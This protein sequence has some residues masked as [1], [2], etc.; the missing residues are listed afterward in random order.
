MNVTCHGH[1]Y[2]VHPRRN[3][4]SVDL[5]SNALPFGQPWYS[6]PDATSNASNYAKFFS[7]SDN[8]VIRV[9]D[10]GDDIIETHEQ[11]GQFK[12]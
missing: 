8:A 12:E 7:R 1:V 2:E 3:H 10:N 11:A 5:I 9:Y 6:E 4:R